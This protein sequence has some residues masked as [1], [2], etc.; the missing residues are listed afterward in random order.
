MPSR[1]IVSY[2]VEELP[3]IVTTT[4]TT[5][6]VRSL[7]PDD[8][9]LSRETLVRRQDQRIKDDITNKLYR[10]EMD[11]IKPSLDVQLQAANFRAHSRPRT[12]NITPE[13]VLR[14]APR[15]HSVDVRRYSTTGNLD[16]YRPNTQQIRYGYGLGRPTEHVVEY[17]S[18]NN[19]LVPYGW[20]G[21]DAVAKL[22]SN[23][24]LSEYDLRRLAEI[25]VRGRNDVPNGTRLKSTEVS[26]LPIVPRI[27]EVSSPPALYRYTT[28]SPAVT[29]SH[30]PVTR[31][32]KVLSDGQYELDQFEK[33]MNRN[34]GPGGLNRHKTLL[35]S[36]PP[37]ASPY[38]PYVSPYSTYSSAYTSR[39]YYSGSYTYHYPYTYT[40]PYY[41]SSYV[42]YS[43]YYD[44]R[45]AEYEHIYTPPTRVTAPYG[46]YPRY[47][48]SDYY[49]SY[50]SRY[51]T[52]SYVR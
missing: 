30:Q 25:K 16:I 48:G 52:Y 10:I 13:P 33:L 18:S 36:S 31:T 46:Y 1:R 20:K 22:P 8:D 42:P 2:T 41:Y 37:Y 44:Q 6:K 23:D 35:Y 29:V 12:R 32:K 45:P 24:L 3:P 5:R 50:P 49:G 19:A 27:R 4:T 47:Y 43:S 14:I 51:Y 17:V 39:P 7:V 38:E 11:R 28:E 34:F 9:G 26:Y 21:H 15:A 40:R